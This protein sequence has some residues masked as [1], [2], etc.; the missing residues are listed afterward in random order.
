MGRVWTDAELKARVE[1]IKRVELR[2]EANFR[3]MPLVGPAVK[4]VLQPYM[5]FLKSI[6]FVDAAMNN[7]YQGAI[8][9]RCGNGETYR[10]I[11]I[12]HLVKLVKG[13]RDAAAFDALPATAI[14]RVEGKKQTI[15]KGIA[16]KLD[17]WWKLLWKWLPEK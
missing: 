12:S 5:G 10:A 4:A 17:P 6:D 7:R 8:E 16:L 9:V 1:G 13:H 3:T 14:I 15:P 2:R 11:D